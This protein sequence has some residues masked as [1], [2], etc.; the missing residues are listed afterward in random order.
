MFGGT[1]SSLAP[2][3]GEDEQLANPDELRRQI[4]ELRERNSR[5]SSAILRINSSLDVTTVLHE[6]VESARVLTRARYGVIVTIDGSGQIQDYVPSGYTSDEQQRL[7]EW[8]DGL[9]L[10]EHFRTIPETLRLSDLPGYVRSLGFLPDRSLPKT[11]QCTPMSHQGVRVGTFFLG[12]KEG[13]QEF[14]RD[15]EEVLVMFSAQA[16][17]AIANARTHRYEQRARADLEALVDTSPVGVAVFNA[18][19]GKPVSFNR[20]AKRIVEFLLTP[21]RAPEQL[22][23][24]ITCRR[25]DGQEVSLEKHPLAQTLSTATTVR[26]EEMVL[27]VPDGRS[28]TTLVNVTPIRSKDGIVE[29]VVAT[30]QDLAPIQELERLRS[31]FLG[32]VT[33]ELRAPLT[34]I[35]GSAATARGASPT[36]DPAVVQQFLR[37]IEEQAD[38]M[39]NLLNDLLDAGRIET[40]TLSVTPVPTEVASLVDQARN[41]FLSGGG[42]HTIH[43]D[44]APGLPW[45]MADRERIVQVLNNLF[46]NAAKHSPQS[47]PIRV[48]AERED[49]HIAISVTDEGKGVPRELL[50]NLFRK[51]ARV[52]GSDQGIGGSG[53]GL[54]ICKGLVEAHGGRIRAESA[55][56]GLGACFTFT[57]PVAAETR[58]GAAAGF[59]L[60]SPRTGRQGLGQ[61]QILVVDDDPQTLRYVRDALAAEGYSPLMTG[62]P[63]EVPR[64][65]T[66]E[67]PRLVLMDLM[68]PGTDGIELMERIP[69]MAHLPVIFISGYGRDELIAKAFE[70]GAADYIVKP[71]SQTELL[72]RVQAA[73]RR[74][75]EPPR[76]FQSGELAIHYEER[77]V[78]LAGLPVRLTAIEYKLLRTLSVNAGRTVTYESLLR[79]VWGRR[80]TSDSRTVRAFV[81]HLRQKLGDDAASPTYIFNERQVGYWMARQSD[82]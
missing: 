39:S 50:P 51:Y 42:K 29:S 58:S 60:D 72:A 6:V 53:L 77:R 28:V 73:L 2:I 34:S 62:D 65:V 9:R 67:Q 35:K 19:T 64:L 49:L 76:T 45:V 33:H 13:G 61:S 23:E 75:G 24:I 55:G 46:S 20:E 78:T 31:E 17:T 18:R 5:L 57:I 71:F 54:A 22:L 79:Q 68:L 4:E 41:T 30:L 27:Q 25:A 66:T 74:R 80:D 69:E 40:G 48:A 59:V 43:I 15:D 8:A 12:E 52:G 11:F 82:V 38:H 26:A 3:S 56:E 37:I 44:L 21:G 36:L 47:L 81:S 16:A 7:E 14:T 10:F 1:E 32:M 63:D 70:M